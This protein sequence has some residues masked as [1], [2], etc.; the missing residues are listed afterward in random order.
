[1]QSHCCSVKK[2]HTLEVKN[3]SKRKFGAT[4]FTT[5]PSTISKTITITS[6][7]KIIA[8]TISTTTTTT[9][10][11]SISHIA[12]AGAAVPFSTGILTH[13][14]C[15]LQ[16]CCLSSTVF[17]KLCVCVIRTAVEPSLWYRENWCSVD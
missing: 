6:A 4:T 3:N 2:E 16:A 7:S 10:Y 15:Y 11:T 12:A 14:H 8:T 9:S 1:M 17:I 5:T 13:K